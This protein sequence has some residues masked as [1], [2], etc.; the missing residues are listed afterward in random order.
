MFDFNLR[1]FDFGF[2][3]LCSK[4]SH[5]SDF[6]SI[7]FSFDV[8]STDSAFSDDSN[9]FAGWE[10]D[11]DEVDDESTSNDFVVFDVDTSSS[12]LDDK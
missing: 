7:A 3:E 9:D 10:L 11:L 1:F 12:S 8:E 6:A 5:R 4:Q 2:E